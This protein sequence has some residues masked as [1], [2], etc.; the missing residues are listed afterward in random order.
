MGIH[1][2]RCFKGL[3]RGKQNRYSTE[4]TSSKNLEKEKCIMCLEV[5]NKLVG[6]YFLLH[7]LLLVYTFGFLSKDA[8]ENHWGTLSKQMHPSSVS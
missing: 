3:G 1:S 2:G 4:G 5:P 6:K 8:R 7:S